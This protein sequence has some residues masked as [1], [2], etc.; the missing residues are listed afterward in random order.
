MASVFVVMGG[1][2]LWMVARGAA[3][4]T[5]TLVFSAVELVLGLLL[6]AAWKLRA[7][8]ALGA[9]LMLADAVL[10]HRFWALGGEARAAQL[11]HFMKNIGF[12]GG[13]LLLAITGGTRHRR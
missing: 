5:S 3:L 2:R 1:Y 13:L 9:A 6:A 7:T 4:P 11:L 10:S 12:V 8:A